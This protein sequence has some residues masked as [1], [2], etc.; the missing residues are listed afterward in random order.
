M[1]G[2]GSDGAAAAISLSSPV[3]SWGVV[4]EHSSILCDQLQGPPRTEC[5]CRQPSYLL[6]RHIYIAGEGG[7]WFSSSKPAQQYRM[8]LGMRPTSIRR[9]WPNHRSLRCLSRVYIVGR[10]ARDKTPAMVTLSYQYIPSIRRMF[11]RWNVLS[12]LSC[13]AYV[14][15]V[16]LPY[17]N[18]LIT[19]AL[20]RV[21]YLCSR[22]AWGLSTLEPWNGRE[23]KLPSQSSC[24]P[25]RQWWWSRGRW[26]G[27]HHPVHTRRW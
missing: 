7:R 23:L 11:L 4:L 1:C 20:Y 18:V 6:R 21:T 26:I 16:S 8:S 27:R 13:P 19:Q 22:T 3:L 10:P 15:H 25:L 14:V 5:R 2:F 9:A 17:N 24:W 12:L